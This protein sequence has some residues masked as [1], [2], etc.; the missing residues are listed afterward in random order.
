M[1]VTAEAGRLG[2]E[3]EYVDAGG[4]RRQV[5]SETIE[6]IAQALRAAA[7]VGREL[8]QL[9]PAFARRAYQGPPGRWWMLGAQLYAV[10]S[11]RNWGHGDFSDLLA[12]IELAGGL[13]AAGVG[14]NPLHSLF[15][16][17]P[18]RPSPYSPNS[19]LFLNPLYIAI[20]QIPEF[21][22]RPLSGI[23]DEIERLR[24]TRYVDYAGVAAL[25]ARCLREA[26]RAFV[27]RAPPQRRAEFDL[28]RRARA[29]MLMRFACFEVLRARLDGPWWTWPPEWRNPDARALASLRCQLGEEIEYRQYV[30]W[31]ADRQLKQCRD[32]AHALGLPI[33]LYLDVAVGVQP[34]GFDAWNAPDVIMRTLAVGAPPDL[35][36]T[37]GQNWGLAGFSGVGLQ[38]RGFAP[39]RDML[40]AAM[41]YAGAIRLDHVL[42]LKRL[43]V[44]PAGMP[45]SEGAYVRL[46]FEQ[47][48][49][50]AAEESMRGQCVVIGE[51]LGAVPDGFR[52]QLA[53]WG[54]WSYQVMLFE[55]DPDGAFHPPDHYAERALATFTTHDL[56]TFAGWLAGLDLRTK[57]M[58]GIGPGETAPE[59]VSAIARLGTA[60]G[61]A[62]DDIAFPAVVRFLATSRARMLVVALDDALGICDQINVPGTVDQH[63]NWRRKLPLEIERMG[64]DA[65]LLAIARIAAEGGR[66]AAS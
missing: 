31:I 16:E 51:D 34:D 9:A 43:Y 2:I 3:V 26:Y 56:A 1:D 52:A 21:A 40:R 42:G 39:Y 62:P 19:R 10:R 7:Q 65:R 46:P 13:G 11:R 15:E 28:F 25:K 59:R 45:A 64:D 32:R 27:A 47:M 23:A 53:Q 44:I 29:P 14:I 50:I 60:L 54:I 55:R 4:R 5:P 41:R 63:P 48:L 20:D 17:M 37:A 12:L 18:E 35:L 6:Q 36:N 49:S 24:R 57:H 38:A 22:E 30:Q 33:G 61:A 66:S 58:L 8:P